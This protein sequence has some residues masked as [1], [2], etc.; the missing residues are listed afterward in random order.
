M[1]LRRD[2][3]TRQFWGECFPHPELHGGGPSSFIKMT[4]DQAAAEFGLM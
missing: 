1:I 2:P 3:L 4:E